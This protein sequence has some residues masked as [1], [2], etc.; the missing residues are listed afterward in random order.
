MFGWLLYGGHGCWVTSWFHPESTPVSS[1]AFSI[2]SRIDAIGC[3]RPMDVPWVLSPQWAV[4]RKM[5]MESGPTSSGLKESDTRKKVERVLGTV[6]C[7]R[8]SH[9]D[10]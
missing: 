9:M 2:V 8:L 6:P 5:P 7:N 3:S 1:R 10:R 4:H